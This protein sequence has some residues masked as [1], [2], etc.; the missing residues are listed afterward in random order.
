[1]NKR[2]IIVIFISL[3][4]IVSGL[5]YFAQE[6][7]K[8][9]D[10]Y[11]SGTIEATQSNLSFQVSGHVT[12]VYA[13]EGQRVSRGDVLAQLDSKEFKARLDQAQAGLDKAVK[14]KEQLEQLLGIYTST[15]PDDVKRAEANVDVAR[16]IMLDSQ[17]NN[18]RY[19]QLFRQG[20]I[21]E[22]EKETIRLGF[23]NSRSRLNEAL[24]TLQQARTSLKKIDTTKKDIESAQSQIDLAKATLDQA[25]I[26]LTYTKLLAPYGGMITSRN[27]EPGE[28]VSPGKEV[29]TLSDLSRVDLK[30]YVD[31]TEIGDVKPGQQVD[32]KVDTFKDRVFRGTVSYISPEAEFTPKIIQTRKERVKLVYLVKISLSNPSFE[33]KTGMPADAYLK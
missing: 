8:N 27:V 16:N 17:K 7:F 9:N 5:V 11:Y 10:M 21:S 24:A 4:A 14:A 6:N 30:I 29:I 19:E 18:D 2:I 31:E 23:D 15:L 25:Q 1:M 32:V 33:L 28:V 22:K 12:D 3:L 26:Q 20:V 13:G